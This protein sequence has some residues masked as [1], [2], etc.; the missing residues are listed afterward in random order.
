MTTRVTPDGYAYLDEF[1]PM[2]LTSEPTY[3]YV[4]TYAV[5]GVRFT[6]YWRESHEPMRWYPWMNQDPDP[7]ALEFGQ[8]DKGV[9]RLD[10]VL[11]GNKAGMMR[12]K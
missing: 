4:A 9:N 1:P 8:I 12:L 6:D 3:H 5:P 11:F 7:P 2:R 10:L